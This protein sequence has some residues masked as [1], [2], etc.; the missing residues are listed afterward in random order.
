MRAIKS[1]RLVAY[2]TQDFVNEIENYMRSHHFST[3]NA[4][5]IW[6]LEKGLNN[7]KTDEVLE[8]RIALLESKLA[9]DEHTYYELLRK[10]TADK[11]L[12]RS[13]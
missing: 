10:R 5:I 11:Y 3:R 8:S 4:A 13:G 2:A 7:T 12:I 6:L 9:A 1:K